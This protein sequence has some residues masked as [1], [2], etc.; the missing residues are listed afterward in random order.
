MKLFIYIDIHHSFSITLQ[1]NLHHN[2]HSTQDP[3]DQSRLNIRP[4]SLPPKQTKIMHHNQAPRP[5]THTHINSTQHLTNKQNQPPP[6]STN[7]RQG[8]PQSTHQITL[9]RNGQ[10]APAA[11]PE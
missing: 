9:V 2:H 7:P 8:S 5:P 6:R 10:F 4:P 1:Q 3:T 11:K